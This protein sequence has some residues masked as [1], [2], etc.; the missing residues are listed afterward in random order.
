MEHFSAGR[1]RASSSEI[2]IDKRWQRG[3]YFFSYYQLWI[4]FAPA[5]HIF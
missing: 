4:E 2:T 3:I 5:T 1:L